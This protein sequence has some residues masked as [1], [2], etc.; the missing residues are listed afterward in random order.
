MNQIQL[1]LKSDKMKKLLSIALILMCSVFA[2]CQKEN[3]S[4]KSEKVGVR[5]DAE[6]A[7]GSIQSSK[8]VFE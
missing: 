2:G 8:T 7:D 4:Q 5:I 6:Y 1:K 3:P